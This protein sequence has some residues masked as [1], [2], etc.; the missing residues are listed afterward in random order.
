[1]PLTVL[2]IV[3]EKVKTDIFDLFNKR[4][5]HCS[6]LIKNFTTFTEQ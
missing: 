2:K 3:L 6:K 4:I 5:K 1:M